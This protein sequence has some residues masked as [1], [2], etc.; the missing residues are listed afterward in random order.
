V[1]D[2]SITIIDPRHPLYGRHYPLL[3]LNADACVIQLRAGLQRRVPLAV[4][5][6]G[7]GLTPQATQ[8]LCS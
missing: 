4:T 5:D 8:P 3:D 7:P 2:E 6:R 1:Q